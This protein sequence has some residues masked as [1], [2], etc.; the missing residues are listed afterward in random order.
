MGKCN[1]SQWKFTKKISF[2]VDFMMIFSYS[3]V[4]HISEWSC[5]QLCI[6][7]KNPHFFN[8]FYVNRRWISR[9]YVCEYTK[10][11]TFTHS[12]GKVMHIPKLWN[13]CIISKN[14]DIFTLFY[15][16][17]YVQKLWTTFFHFILCTF[18]SIM[19]Y[20]RRW[21]YEQFDI[22]M[23]KDIRNL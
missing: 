3:Q 7:F 9:E 6:T 11:F 20:E 12:C 16:R 17:K 2:Y 15:V 10:L 13:L 4:T 5:A 8:I 22:Y 23:A 14:V 21:I 18:Y 19:Y 1:I